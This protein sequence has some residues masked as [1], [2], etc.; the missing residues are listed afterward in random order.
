MIFDFGLPILD[1]AENGGEILWIWGRRRQLGSD[2]VGRDLL[3]GHPAGSIVEAN[4]KLIEDSGASEKVKPNS[5]AL[6]KANGSGNLSGPDLDWEI[7]NESRNKT[8]VAN[9]DHLRPTAFPV[10]SNALCVIYAQDT[11]GCS[12][13]NKNPDLMG[14]NR[15]G[16]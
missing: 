6:R 5:K 11:K 10:Y 13:I 1:W 15:D 12:R 4:L 7:M 3:K 16:N 2:C 8:S 9:Y 14:I